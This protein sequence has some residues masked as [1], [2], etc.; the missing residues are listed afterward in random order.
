MDIIVRGVEICDTIV[1][2]LPIHMSFGSV[3][4]EIIIPPPNRSGYEYTETL[5]RR[6]D[7]QAEDE[8]KLAAASV[9]LSEISVEELV[10]EFHEDSVEELI[11]ELE[12]ELAEG[13]QSLSEYLITSPILA[14]EVG[15]PFYMTV[16]LGYPTDNN[17]RNVRVTFA[18]YIKNVASSEIYPTWSEAAVC[19]NILC[20]IS[21]ALNRVYTLWYRSRGHSFD[22][23]NTTAYDQAFVYGRNI[24]ENI[25]RIVDDIFNLFLRRT[26]R[27]E[28]FFASYCNGTTSQCA[29]LSQWGAQEMALRGYSTIEILRYYY[30]NDIQIVESVNFSE[31]A[32]VFPGTALREGSS[33]DDV[34]KMQV[35]LNRIGGNYHVPPLGRPDGVFDGLMKISVMEFQRINSLLIDGIIGKSSWYAITR[36]YVAVKQLAELESE[37]E[38]IGIGEAPPD[39]VLRLGD[40]GE[41][42]VELQFLLNFIAEFY[43]TIP[44]VIEDGVF[45]EPTKNA[46][47]EFQREFGLVADGVVGY[48][49]WSALYAVYER[50]TD[51]IS[52]IDSYPSDTYY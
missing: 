29:G 20:Q 49:T 5:D 37:G 15:I 28:P 11:E 19:A 26:G 51:G 10:E 47:T 1:S 39:V 12:E 33:G 36:I 13:S 16:H 2:V 9:R 45:R 42:L 38:R 22:I 32:G 23:T 44:F 6:F 31:N 52:D 48:D 17:A 3:Y 7:N 25:S 34:L 27:R 4:R 24:F 43:P 8:P 21:Y 35:Y 40:R 30:P 14:N 41:H 50:I 18:D 46:V